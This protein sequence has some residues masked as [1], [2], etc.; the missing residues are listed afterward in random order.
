VVYDSNGTKLGTVSVNQQLDGGAWN[1]LGS[2][3]F[4]AGW[5]KVVLS[6]WTTEGSVVIA[7]AIRVR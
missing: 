5:N 1:A 6:R 7:D 2:F 3:R 4:T